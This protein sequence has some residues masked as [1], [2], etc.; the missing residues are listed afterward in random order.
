VRYTEIYKE[1]RR[2]H[3]LGLAVHWLHP[4][5]KRPVGMGWT[6]GPRKSWQ[7]LEKEFKPEMNVGVRTGN[8][9]KIGERYLTVIDVDIKSA[10][11]HHRLEANAAVKALLG[12]L[13]PPMVRSGRGGG[14][15]HYYVVTEKPFASFNPA[16]ST[17]FVKLKLNKPVTRRDR[18]ILSE[19]DIE[20][21][22]R[23]V[24]AWEIS[25]MNEGRQVVVPPSRHPDTG[26]I[27]EWA[28]PIAAPSELP[29]FSVPS[30]NLGNTLND[31]KAP[32]AENAVQTE[33]LRISEVKP[34][35]VKP[36]LKDF[37]FEAVDVDLGWLPGIS[38]VVVHKIKT[39]EGVGDRS[40]Y[41]L[42][43]ASALISAGLNDNEVLSVL[44]DPTTALGQA[45]LSH[46]GE[47][48]DR[49]RAAFWV[50]Q[51]T[52]GKV[53]AERSPELVFAHAPLPPIPDKTDDDSDW[54]QNL[55][56]TQH[57]IP[58][59]TIEN[60][61]T[62]LQNAVDPHVIRKNLFSFCDTY[63]V[64]TPWGG[65]VGATATD[66]DIARI[67]YWLGKKYRFEPPRNTVEAA[68]VEISCQGAYDPVKEMLEKLPEWD[69]T[70]RLDTWLVKNFEAR[71]ANEPGGAD[72]LAQVFRKWMIAMVMRV[73]RPGAKFDWMP[74]FEGAQGVGKSSFGKIL[75]GDDYFLDW[76]PDLQDK[77]SALN[78]QGMWA[79]EM[80]EL[81]QFRKNQLETIKAFLTR[82][83]DKVRPPYGRRL[84][85]RDRRCVFFGTTN[86]DKYLVDETGNRRFKPIM[87]GRLNFEA[88][89]NERLQLFAEAKATYFQLGG[90]H[91][92]VI[93]DI[94][95]EGQLFEKAIQA[96]KIVEDD[97]SVMA[98]QI[99]SYV[100]KINMKDSTFNQNRFRI[101]DLFEGGGPLQSWRRDNRN[102]Q[103]ASKALSKLNSTSWEVHKYKFW[104]L[105]DSLKSKEID[106]PTPHTHPPLQK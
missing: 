8:A 103:F 60:V 32:L 26:A 45:S 101:I 20:G 87:V 73:Y 39:C 76:L 64:K 90:P 95:G 56:K 82:T 72:Y 38:D 36:L 48:R 70:C 46:A 81:S 79:V 19:P 84:V 17:E 93:L 75:V 10:E 53:K 67:Q 94:D 96:E 85:E 41:M 88:L 33:S 5:S 30:D 55:K 83:T 105:A 100:E 52:Y 24:R 59:K 66:D 44:T 14:S 74:I 35:T 54:R 78:L 31:I 34:Q 49:R 89:Q 77:E 58:F 15:R 106:N 7:E 23:M 13:K 92:Q 98:V 3:D 104:K 80:G 43:A 86:R 6:T 69:G 57:G 99:K 37:K 16:A 22:Y 2:L 61:V 71:G 21:G 102:L 50:S 51:F 42:V 18:E 1:A 65:V 27:Y 68:L 63:T 91:Q 12:G 40:A 97:A 47:T 9:S 62:V 29:V 11:P 4:R 25:V 28:R